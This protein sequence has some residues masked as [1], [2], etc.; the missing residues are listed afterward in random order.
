MMRELLDDYLDGALPG[1]Q[2][3]EVERRLSAEPPAAA[4]LT[5]MHAERALR[6]AAL[7]SFEATAEEAGQL[8][9]RTMAACD[10]RAT[11]GYVGVWLRRG[12]AVAAALALVVGS[13]V[14]GRMTA[15]GAPAA[16]D[17]AARLDP[18]IIY[19]VM[20][21]G[22]TGEKEVREFASV[23]EASDFMNVAELKPGEPQVAAVDLNR[24]GSF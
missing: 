18:Q 6:R 8:A 7:A 5:R 21:F 1:P 9:A 22:E 19:R 4:L 10:K 20:Y 12:I 17:A 14:M 24:P 2:R 13:F 15:T 23:D 3:A 16:P 11:V